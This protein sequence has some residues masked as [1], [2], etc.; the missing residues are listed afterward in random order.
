MTIF[1]IVQYFPESTCTIHFWCLEVY[2]EVVWVGHHQ[3]IDLVS[4]FACTTVQKEDNS[5]CEVTLKVLGVDSKSTNNENSLLYVDQSTH[6]SLVS[7]VVCSCRWLCVDAV[8][9]PGV[10][11]SRTSLQSFV[12]NW[13]ICLSTLEGNVVTISSKSFYNNKQTWLTSTRMHIICCQFDQ[14]LPKPLLWRDSL[15]NAWYTVCQYWPV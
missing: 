6:L 8:V 7:L 10:N 2:V 5:C 9:A 12:F 14:Q 3:S 13:S 11:L 1:C 4:L 15:R